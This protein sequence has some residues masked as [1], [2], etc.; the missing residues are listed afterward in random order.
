M[1]R[2]TVTGP[3]PAASWA[4]TKLATVVVGEFFEADRAEGGGEVVVDVVA[5]AGQRGGCLQGTS[6]DV[7]DHDTLASFGRLSTV[8]ITLRPT[9]VYIVTSRSGNGTA[10]AGDVPV[11]A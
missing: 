4:P 11:V 2:C 7:R 6:N 3:R 9:C 8:S 5:V 1:Q 10:G